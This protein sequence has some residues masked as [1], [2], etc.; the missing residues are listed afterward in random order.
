MSMQT[1]QRLF[2]R[3]KSHHHCSRVS[4]PCSCSQRAWWCWHLVVVLSHTPIC[5]T[6]R[7]WRVGC[8]CSRG[9]I[10]LTR[11]KSHQTLVSVRA[12]RMQPKNAPRDSSCCVWRR[13]GEETLTLN[14]GCRN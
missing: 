2:T 8:R 7:D 3:A 14:I 6:G 4:T 10:L 13:R 12:L 9:E 5:M 1:G 11:A